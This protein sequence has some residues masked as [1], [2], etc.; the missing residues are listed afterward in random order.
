[1]KKECRKEQNDYS[2][3]RISWE[4]GLRTEIIGNCLNLTYILPW[5][6]D[7]D[8]EDQFQSNY[9]LRLSII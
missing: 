3:V 4:E 9:Y 6:R 2:S 5:V 1:M 8:D 7:I